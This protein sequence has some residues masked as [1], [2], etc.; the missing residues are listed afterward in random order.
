[1]NSFEEKEKSQRKGSKFIGSEARKM[2]RK[3][4]IC[5]E[6]TSYQLVLRKRKTFG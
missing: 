5:G 2:Y 3:L 1:M 4:V 6:Q